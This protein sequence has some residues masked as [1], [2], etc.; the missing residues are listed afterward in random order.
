MW[1]LKNEYSPLACKLLSQLT[2]L[3]C[4]MTEFYGIELGNF[5]QIHYIVQSWD[6]NSEI[7]S[8]RDT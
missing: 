8:F 4:D 6:I 1:P 2:T 3:P 5:H 7:N